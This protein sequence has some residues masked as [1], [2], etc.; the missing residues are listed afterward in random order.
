MHGARKRLKPLKTK[1]KL[2]L[3]SA[4]AGDWIWRCR[5]LEGYP[6]LAAR[7]TGLPRK[8]PCKASIGSDENR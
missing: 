1:H 6:V 5:L 8:T 3:T 2:S 7:M 4:Q